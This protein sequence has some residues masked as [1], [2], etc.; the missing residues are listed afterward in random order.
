MPRRK[1]EVVQY[2]GTYRF[3]GATFALPA[4]K[5]CSFAMA[6]LLIAGKWKGIAWSVLQ[7]QCIR[8]ICREDDQTC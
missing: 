3:S 6:L 2:V 5:C 1:T 8:T 7:W 4:Q